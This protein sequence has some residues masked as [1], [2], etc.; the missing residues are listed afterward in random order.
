MFYIIDE[1]ITT[2]RPSARPPRAAA[3]GL[4]T[5]RSGRAAVAPGARRAGRDDDD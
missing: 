3:P 2:D 4:A 5:T 1:M